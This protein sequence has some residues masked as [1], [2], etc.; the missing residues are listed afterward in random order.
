MELYDFMICNSRG[1]ISEHVEVLVMGTLWMVCFL[2]L[3]CDL[4]SQVDWGGS[5]SMGLRR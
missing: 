2:E 4:L 3:V 5:W 1:G